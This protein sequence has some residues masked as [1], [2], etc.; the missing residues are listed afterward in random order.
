MENIIEFSNVYKIYKLYRSDKERV[1]GFFFGKK[2]MEKE[3]EQ[4][5]L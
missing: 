5:K 4:E 1:L 2:E 3:G